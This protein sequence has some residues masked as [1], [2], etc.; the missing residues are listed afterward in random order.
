MADAG[1]KRKYESEDEWGSGAESSVSDR[2]AIDEDDDL[3]IEQPHSSRHDSRQYSRALRSRTTTRQSS[4]H[5]SLVRDDDDDD[6]DLKEEPSIAVTRSLRARPPR[7]ATLNF[8]SVSNRFAG[9]DQDEL[10]NDPRTASTDEEDGNFEMITSDLLGTNTKRSR[11]GRKKSRRL[12]LLG[13]QARASARAAA[14]RRS[15]DSDIEFEAPRRSGRST[16]NKASMY[17]EALMDE[18]SFYVVDDKAP[19]APKIIS[20]REVFLPPPPDSPFALM[21]LE[22]CHTCGGSKQRGQ[23]VHCQG[24]TLSY[25]KNCLGYRSARDHMVTKVG[26]ENFVLQCRYC[27]GIY[28]KKDPR[29]PKHS[30]CQTCLGEGRACAPFSEKKTA[31]QEENL[32]EQNGGVDPITVVSSELI[33]NPENVLFRCVTCHRGWHV[34]H[35]PSTSSQAIGTDVKSERLKDYSVDWQCNDCSKAQQKIHRLV[36]WRPRKDVSMQS[37]RASY[38]EVSEDNKEYLIKWET[39]SYAHCTWMPGAWVFGIAP[40]TMRTS[41]GKRDAEHDLLKMSEQEAI[42]EEFVMPDVILNTKMDSHAPKSRTKEAELANISKVSKIYVKFQGLGYDDVVWDTPPTEDKGKIYEAF[43]EAYY[44]YIEG[45][46]FQTESFNKIRDRV[47]S[48]K[49]STFTEIDEQPKGLQRGKL[50]GYQLE[51]LNWLLGNYHHGRSV[52]LADEMGLGKTIQVVS[53]LTSLI[54]D[55]PKVCCDMRN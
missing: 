12:Q 8:M 55:K 46:Y 47:R 50:M 16:R 9:Q 41:F 22:K 35:L 45:K 52:V 10:L 19:G 18:D 14:Q 53:L 25:H 38:A 24:C 42:P 49:S 34:D 27:V 21:H 7:Q 30:A 48:F 4:R 3:A 44:E 6:D 33:D 36:A 26:E 31:R 5:A 11:R 13:S 43:V 37:Q 28:T 17:D 15:P 23:I 54:Q 32:R 51:G 29:A 1:R 40:A 2:M 20:I 39:T